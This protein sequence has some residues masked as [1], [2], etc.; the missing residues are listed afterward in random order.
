MV[1]NYSFPLTTE[2]YVHRIGRTG[3]AGKKGVAHTFFTQENKVLQKMF[4][5][6]NSLVYTVTTDLSHIMSFL[7]WLHVGPCWRTCQCS[8]RSW[9][10]RSCSPYQIWY[11]CEEKGL[12]KA[13]AF[14][15]FTYLFD[16]GTVRVLSHWL[17]VDGWFFLHQIWEL[18]YGNT[19]AFKRNT[20]FIFW[21]IQI[22]YSVKEKVCIKLMDSKFSHIW[23]VWVQYEFF[24]S[25]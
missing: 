14:Q 12:Y 5:L 15:I 20:K 18:I 9:A 2:D 7:L 21:K 10:D 1:I 13:H 11:S 3:R 24:P 4:V 23:L 19:W 6:L 16:L 8:P 17:V 25:S 22:W